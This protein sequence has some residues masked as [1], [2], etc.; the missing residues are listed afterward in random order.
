M[1]YSPISVRRTSWRQF[2]NM[3]QSS[4]RSAPYEAS[5]QCVAPNL[6]TS[7]GFYESTINGHSVGDLSAQIE[8][9]VIGGL[10]YPSTTQGRTSPVHVIGSTCLL[11]ADKFLWERRDHQKW[12]LVCLTLRCQIRN[13]QGISATTN[14]GWTY[15]EEKTVY[16]RFVPGQ[17]QRFNHAAASFGAPLPSVGYNKPREGMSASHKLH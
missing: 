7:F 11:F 8:M 5:H 2:V 4:L 3:S 12:Q 15:R 9:E 13:P 17:N 16:S 10:D 6:T 14:L 1:S